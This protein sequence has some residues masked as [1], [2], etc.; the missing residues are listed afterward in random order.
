VVICHELTDEPTVAGDGLDG[1]HLIVTHEPAVPLHIRAQDGSQ[2]SNDLICVL[3]H[4]FKQSIL[5][6]LRAHLKIKS[7]FIRRCI[8]QKKIFYNDTDSSDL[9]DRLSALVEQRAVESELGHSGSDVARYLGVTNACVTRLVASGKSLM[10]LILSKRD[11]CPA[12]HL[13]FYKTAIFS[14]N[15]VQCVSA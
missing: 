5:V 8:E 12:S 6:S 14:S 13:S 1:G 2:F 7:H 11:E 10:L 15:C 9:I 3:R 4:V